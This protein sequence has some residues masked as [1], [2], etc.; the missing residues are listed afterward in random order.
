M[1]ETHSF[2]HRKPPTGIAC[3]G[4]EPD[5]RGQSTRPSRMR[6]G[7]S[8]AD[9]QASRMALGQMPYL[10]GDRMPSAPRR[11]HQNG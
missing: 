7:R 8:T 6:L 11:E 3:C 5:G 9:S 4:R 2:T 10:P 1:K